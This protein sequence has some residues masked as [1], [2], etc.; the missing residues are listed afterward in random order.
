VVLGAMMTEFESLVVSKL[1]E[2]ENATATNAATLTALNERLFDG[3]SS[4]I[5][6]LQADIDEIKEAR[7]TDARWERL[8]NVL[9]YSTGPLLIMAHEVMRKMGIAI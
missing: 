6:N 2:I 7:K 4:V 3:P 1:S 9:H 5:T 8:H